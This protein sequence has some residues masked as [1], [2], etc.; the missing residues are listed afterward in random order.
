[1]HGKWY[2]QQSNSPA[3][4]S[5]QLDVSERRPG[6]IEEEAAKIVNCSAGIPAVYGVVSLSVASLDQPLRAIQ[7]NSL[8][9]GAE[10]LKFRGIE[11]LL[12]F[13]PICR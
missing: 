4:C 12:Q 10:C 6:Q 13:F 11:S 8:P 2:R 7:P 3:A 1:V 9:G 5:I